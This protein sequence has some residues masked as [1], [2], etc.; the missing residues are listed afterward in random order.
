MATIGVGDAQ[1]I[2]QG[3][4]GWGFGS[5]SKGG[6]G[7]SRVTLK[8]DLGDGMRIRFWDDV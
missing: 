1:W 5:T 2:P 4:T 3:H 8:F 7:F 6:G